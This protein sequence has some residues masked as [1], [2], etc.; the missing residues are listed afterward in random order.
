MSS[1]RKKDQSEHRFTVTDLALDLYEHTTTV[2]ANPK[3]F[4]QS[5]D[6]LTN[7]INYEA[8]MIYHCCRS[9]NE[10]YDNRYQDQAKTRLELQAE[11]MEHCR[12]LKTDIRLA[13][14]KRHLRAKK[15]IAWNQYVNDALN[16]IKAWHVSERK[17]YREQYGL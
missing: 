2:T 15:V 17:R 16:A 4:D 11:A 14:K 8:S 13:Q 9:A 1:V 6:E 5:I 3:L 10:D 7:R 12:W